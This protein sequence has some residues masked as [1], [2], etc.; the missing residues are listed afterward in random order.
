MSHDVNQYHREKFDQIVNDKQMQQTVNCDD[1]F[2]CNDR[3]EIK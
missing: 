3:D 2:I 1:I